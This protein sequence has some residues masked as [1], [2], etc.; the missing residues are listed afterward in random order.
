MRRSRK[1]LAARSREI[2]N[3]CREM[4]V[5]SAQALSAHAPI[6]IADCD[7]VVVL[8]L[9][10]EG[11]CLRSSD[12]LLT[13]KTVLTM[14]RKVLSVLLLV[15]QLLNLLP[16]RFVRR[17]LVLMGEDVWQH[18][19]LGWTGIPQKIHTLNETNGL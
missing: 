15:L 1:S 16:G 10:H 17:E 2:L 7:A 19:C 3:G 9:R 4:P 14:M 11:C 5:I 6:V 13:L 12:D 18:G 8:L